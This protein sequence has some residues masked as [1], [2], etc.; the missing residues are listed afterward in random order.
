MANTDK[1]TGKL[2]EKVENSAKRGLL[3]KKLATILTDVPVEFEH[4]EISFRKARF[5]KLKE[6]FDDIEFKRLYENLYRIFHSEAGNQ[7]L[8]TEKA[9]PKVKNS[10]Q[11][12]VQLDLLLTMRIRRRHLCFLLMQG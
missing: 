2:R 7:A 3:S 4:E 6:I 9:T 11:E 1:L 8:E 10:G 12:A 5:P